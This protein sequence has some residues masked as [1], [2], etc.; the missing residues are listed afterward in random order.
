MAS[1]YQ[2]TDPAPQTFMSPVNDALRAANELDNRLAALATRLCGPTPPT[3]NVAAGSG[4]LAS[5]PNGVFDEVSDIG[6][7]TSA[8]LG[9][10]H[11][12][13]NRIDRAL[14]LT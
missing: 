2:E 10:A 5:V 9:S 13:L 11:E 14:P 6:R 3:N 1:I 7:Q 8:A 12:S 4:K